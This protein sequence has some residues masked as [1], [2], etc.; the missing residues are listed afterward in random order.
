[1]VSKHDKHIES[2]CDK[3]RSEYDLILCNVPLYSCRRRR[4]AEID[5]LG[6]NEKYCDVFEVKCSHRITK[7]RKQ[8]NKIRRLMSG[9]R[10]T[11]FYCGNSEEL[12]KIKPR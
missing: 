8:L 12:V 11:F 7:A 6:V 10:H 1:M 4:V 9:V 2:L 5:I 3:L